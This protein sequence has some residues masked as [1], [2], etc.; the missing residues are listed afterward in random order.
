MITAWPIPRGLTTK[1]PLACDGRGRPLAIL[2]APGPRHGGICAQ[3]LLKRMFGGGFRR[4]TV[5]R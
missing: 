4:S 3:P 5:E 2:I 1:I